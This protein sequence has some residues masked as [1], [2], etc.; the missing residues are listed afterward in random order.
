MAERSYRDED[1]AAL[2]T[3]LEALRG[4]VSTLDAEVR[5]AQQHVDLTMR[6]QLRC[7]ACRGR[8]IGHVPKVLDRG[9]GDS[10]E[11]M[12]LFKPSWWYGETQGH[13]E[14]YVCMS[15]GLVELWVRDAGALVEHKDFLIVH[16]GDAAGGEAPYR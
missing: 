14:A 15:C 5:R 9:E 12:A 4:L 11:D 3:E 10:R 2:R 8:R 16:D 13:L 1:I 7:R 6:G